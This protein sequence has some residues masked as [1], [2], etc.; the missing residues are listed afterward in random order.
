MRFAFPLTAVLLLAGCPNYT[1]YL[2]DGGHAKVNCDNSSLGVPVTILDRLGMPAPQAVI[3]I[4]YL[5]YSES[6]NL[7]ADDRGVAVVKEKYGPGT[8]RVQGSVN[9]LRTSAAEI[10]FVGN[11]CASSVTPRSLTLRLQ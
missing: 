1:P 2:P 9:D 3:S 6:E 10:S 7:I 4:D 5:S 11:E 8:V